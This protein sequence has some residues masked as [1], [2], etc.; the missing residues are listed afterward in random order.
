M[1]IIPIPYARGYLDLDVPEENLKAVLRSQA[2]SFAALGSETEIARE[3]LHA[4]IASP[5]LREL[6]KNKR[7]ITI[8]TSDHTRPVP[9]AITMPLLL[10]EIRAG[11]AEAEITIL[12]ATGTHRAMTEQEIRDRFGETIFHDERIVNHDAR[13]DRQMMDVGRLPSGGVLY[14]NRL[15][16]ECDLLVAEGFIEPHFFAGFS[17]GRKAVLSGVASATSVNGN[18]CS[19]FIID[20]NSRTGI[21]D[22]NPIHK[23]M[24]YAA[25]QAQLTFIFNVV[26][27]SEKKIIKAHAG[28]PVVAHKQGCAF[29]E[30]LASVEPQTADIVVTSN[31]GYPL[32]QNIYQS[33]KGMTAAE[34][35]VR[36]GGVIIIAAACNDGHGGE[37]FHRMFREHSNAREV[38]DT[39]LAVP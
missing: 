1:A 27:N 12:I 37:S 9:S 33:V 11:N 35:T 5:P 15:A 38:M 17:G 21:L 4:P 13:D 32:D 23:D 19:K 10:E 25:E 29:V 36:D 8:I 39:I 22:G 3:A 20:R 24:L 14:L 16:M 31:R 26:I 18:H 28:H 34:A 2:D 30:E 7:T 6:A